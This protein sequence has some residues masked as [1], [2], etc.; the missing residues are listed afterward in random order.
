M[1]ASAIPAN[2]SR[3]P[4]SSGS[5]GSKMKSS[6]RPVMRDDSVCGL[7]RNSL[8][9][10]QLLA[11]AKTTATTPVLR[12]ASG[13][14]E[15]TPVSESSTVSTTSASRQMSTS[16]YMVM[17][18]VMRSNHCIGVWPFSSRRRGFRRP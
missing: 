5:T 11:V 12:M 4:P 2:L 3:L 7:T 9:N 8:A 6:S 17:V 14:C 16:R 18:P 1:P 10:I 13:D 15:I